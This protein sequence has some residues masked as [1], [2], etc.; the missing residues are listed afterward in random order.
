MID[1]KTCQLDERL[2]T[3]KQLAVRVGISVRQVRQLIQ[4]RQLEHVF[5]GCRI[6]VPVGAFTRF[7]ET[8]KV[9]PCQEGIKDRDFV[10]SQSAM[11]STSPGPN[12]AAAAS[13]ALARQ[14]AHKLKS[15]LRN[16]SSA[17]DAGPAPVIPLRS[18]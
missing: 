2:E 16:G 10:G 8:R 12:T 3:P 11:A 5:I 14:T 6:L 17:E 18:S 1:P 15:A 4:T 7:L 13:A 9:K